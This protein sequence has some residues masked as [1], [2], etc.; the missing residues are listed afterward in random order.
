MEKQDEPRIRRDEHRRKLGQMDKGTMD[1]LARLP[2]ENGGG[3][4]A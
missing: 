3:Q 2:G 1:K 4:D